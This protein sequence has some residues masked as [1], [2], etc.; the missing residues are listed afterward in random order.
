MVN[1]LRACTCLSNTYTTYTWVVRLIPLLI[2]QKLA[3]MRA[4]VHKMCM[5]CVRLVYVLDKHVHAHKSSD[6]LIVIPTFLGMCTCLMFNSKKSSH[7][8]NPNAN[9]DSY[10]TPFFLP[11]KSYVSPIFL[12]F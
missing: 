6:I 10:A 3:Q 5:C 11:C 2:E 8:C 4:F 12:R 9:F 1:K 7:V